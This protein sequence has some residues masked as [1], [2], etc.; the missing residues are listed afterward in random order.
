MPKE[1]EAGTGPTPVSPAGRGLGSG[2][3]RRVGQV[4]GTQVRLAWALVNS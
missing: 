3:A 1:K 4:E 2:S